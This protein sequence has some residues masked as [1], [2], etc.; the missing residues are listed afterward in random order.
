MVLV[1]GEVDAFALWAK[2]AQDLDRF[3]GGTGDDVRCPGVEFRGFA[4]V[5][6]GVG[7]TELQVDCSRKDVEPLVAIV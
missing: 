3:A 1:A 6:R 4:G 2:E 7:V 5:D